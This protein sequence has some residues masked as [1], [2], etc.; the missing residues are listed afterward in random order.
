MQYNLC[1]DG[2]I[3]GFHTVPYVREQLAALPE[4]EPV[5]IRINSLGGDVNAALDIRQMLL[6]HP[7]TV[8]AYIY[9]FTASAATLV[10]TGA[11]RI[12]M[13]KFAFLLIHH[14]SA[15]LCHFEEANKE[16]LQELVKKMQALTGDLD[17]IDKLFLSVYLEHAPNADP[18]ALERAMLEERW[19]TPAEA[20]ALG[21]VDEIAGGEKQTPAKEEEQPTTAPLE[22]TN[23]NTNKPK[24]P[25]PMT[26]QNLVS[27]V[28][29]SL[30]DARRFRA[31]ADAERQQADE[32]AKEA[33]ENKKKADAA[34]DRAADLQKTLDESGKVIEELKARTA[35][36]EKLNADL[37]AQVS[38]LQNGDGADTPDTPAPATTDPAA[39][40][41][42][43]YDANTPTAKI[44]ERFK[45]LVQ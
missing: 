5:N 24:D 7:A 43:Y 45:C 34:T 19:L 30:P 6:D 35:D 27:S 26:M 32:K 36:L 15:E 1:L 33:D 2:M 20:L 12:I 39:S 31:A 16:Q 44:F 40:A 41:K 25:Q 10:A 17:K 8:T 18:A 22:Q 3:N 23:E 38:A 14:A 28:F 42:A 37:N 4:G 11:S 9:G 29:A 13:D 21:L